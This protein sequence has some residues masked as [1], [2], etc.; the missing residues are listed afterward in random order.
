MLKELV[1]ILFNCP[2]GKELEDCPLMII[3]NM[4]T[5]GRK[6]FVAN[7]FNEQEAVLSF[8]KKCRQKRETLIKTGNSK[9]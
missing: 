8:H 6:E 4:G 5:K 2:M 1:G 9:Y 3:R 7:K